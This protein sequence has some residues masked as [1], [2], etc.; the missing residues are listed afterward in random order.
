M[1]AAASALLTDGSAAA[2]VVTMQ[3]MAAR[4]R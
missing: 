2:E 1:I 3:A 4:T